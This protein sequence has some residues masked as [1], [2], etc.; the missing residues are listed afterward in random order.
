MPRFQPR[1]A[2]HM[3]RRSICSRLF[4]L[5]TRT[6]TSVSAHMEYVRR[7]PA[8]VR[9]TWRS[10][11]SRAPNDNLPCRTDLQRQIRY[12]QSR[13]HRLAF[14]RQ[15]SRIRIVGRCSRAANRCNAS[16]PSANSRIVIV[17]VRRVS[18]ILL[19]VMSSR[20]STSS[21]FCWLAH[22]SAAGRIRISGR[23]PRATRKLI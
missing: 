6:T 13:V 1:S 23:G 11:Q 22:A 7:L 17:R 12:Q 18:S 5:G 21:S 3:C 15:L 16:M 10:P 8:S 20:S 9:N 2:I 14:E 4:V 19:P